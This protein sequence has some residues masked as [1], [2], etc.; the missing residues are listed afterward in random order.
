[1][2]TSNTFQAIEADINALQELHSD[3]E[4]QTFALNILCNQLHYA[5]NS[6]RPL[7]DIERDV[8]TDNDVLDSDVFEKDTE[9]FDAIRSIQ[10]A[11][12]NCF[13]E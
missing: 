5:S 3:N 4:E 1:M 13:A 2:N 8:M 6:R 10:H 9:A 11:I 7:E 12:V